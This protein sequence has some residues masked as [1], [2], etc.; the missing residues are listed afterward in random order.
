MTDTP[1]YPDRRERV[2]LAKLMEGRAD[3]QVSD[4]WLQFPETAQENRNGA[5]K[6]ALMIVDVM[7]TNAEGKH[8]KL[9]ELVLAREDLL[10]ILNR[11]PVTPLGT[12]PLPS[13]KPP[14]E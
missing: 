7:S 5:G 10:Q 2:H 1:K 8:R 3:C 4:R 14:H 6:H 9:C 13:P 11:M 12:T